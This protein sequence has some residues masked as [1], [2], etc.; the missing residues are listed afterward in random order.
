VPIFPP[1]YA[2]KD[3]VKE[4]LTEQGYTSTRASNLDN[5]DAT[6]SSRASP[7]DILTDP[8]VKIDASKIN[9]NLDVAVSTRASPSDI[10]VDPSVK[11]DAS[12]LDVAV[13]S[14]ASPGDILKD[15]AYKVDAQ[16]L[17]YAQ[18][19]LEGTVSLS[20]LDSETT[21]VEVTPGKPAYLEGYIDAS[22]LASGDTIEIKWYVMIQSGGE[23]KLIH[24]ETYN[25]PLDN[26]LIYIITAPAKY[27]LKIS[28][29]QTAGTLRSFPY[30]FFQ[31]QIQ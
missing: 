1:T 2:T 17:L 5:L 8:A 20:A 29:T 12:K 27:G 15:T 11:I 18:D 13:S 19:P 22:A 31:R 6:V 24:K 4:A 26:P 30:Q 7:G 23:Y 21:V 16:R 10:L 9:N 14:R 25:G 3:I 28:I